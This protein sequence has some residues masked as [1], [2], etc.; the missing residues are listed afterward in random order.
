MACLDQHQ[1][2]LHLGLG[3]GMDGESSTVEHREIVKAVRNRDPHG[4]R[5]LMLDHISKAEDRIAT[6]LKAGGY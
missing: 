2:P 6:A 5:A 4:A 3:I 1:R